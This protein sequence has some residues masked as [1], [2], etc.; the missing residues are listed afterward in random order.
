MRF[1]FKEA[2]MKKKL[3]IGLIV[4]LAAALMSTGP[5]L[6]AK[7][8][9]ADQTKEK[10]V[11]NEAESQEETEAEKEKTKKIEKKII[12]ISGEEGKD[13]PAVITIKEGD[14]VKKI[15][16][17]KPITIKKCKEGDFILMDSEGNK[18]KVLEG[19]PV[20]EGEL[21]VIKL[22]KSVITEEG[23]DLIWKEK[24]DKGE[25]EIKIW[26]SEG[27]DI[28][29][30]KIDEDDVHHW[31]YKD[32]EGLHHKDIHVIK[33][34]CD[35]EGD[36]K[37][38]GH[39][40]MEPGAK[41]GHIFHV[42][43]S[44]EADEEIKAIIQ[45]I[46]DDLKKIK[47]NEDAVNE[48]TKL[49]KELEAKLGEHHSA[50]AFKISHDKPNTFSIIKK[51]DGQETTKDVYITQDTDKTTMKVV[52]ADDGDLEVG[53]AFGKDKITK[54]IYETVLKRLQKEMADTLVIDPE[55]DAESGKIMFKIKGLEKMDLS[56]EIINQIKNIIK[57]EIKK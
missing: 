27:D 6:A 3:L 18:I 56:K 8:E 10:A 57:E 43:T 49:V 5:S 30:V 37:K 53:F 47:K 21:E 34:D 39:V 26:I 44:H 33:K 11:E 17:N 36:I 40:N 52:V 28:K 45:S 20:K 16:V 2:R 13:T 46:K 22:D 55:F 12:F 31:I 51:K 35:H 14:D 9:T 48:I 15:K 38:E 1:R 41:G 4:I 42:G 7:F 24:G 29:A 23:E 19:H 54:E 32:E 25:K 50:H